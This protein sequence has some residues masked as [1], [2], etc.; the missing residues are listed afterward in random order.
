MTCARPSEFSLS[1]TEDLFF[2]APCPYTSIALIRQL[3][4]LPLSLSGESQKEGRAQT[5]RA[6]G[7]RGTVC[8]GALPLL[9]TLSARAR[10]AI[11]I[12][13]VLTLDAEWRTAE[14]GRNWR[15]YRKQI[16]PS[17]SRPRALASNVQPTTTRRLMNK[18]RI[19]FKYDSE[20]LNEVLF[21]E[22]F[23]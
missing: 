4:W 16:F 13:S 10:H 18:N 7:G 9:A 8:S 1:E 5:S 14:R 3:Y 2:S 23:G 11:L 12:P 15:R 21:S 17:V 22:I 20:A 19:S 6:Q